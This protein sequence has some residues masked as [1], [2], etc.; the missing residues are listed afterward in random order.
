MRPAHIEPS[1]R[2]PAVFHRAAREALRAMPRH[3]REVF[4]QAIDDAQCGDKPINASPLK[5]YRGAGVLEIAED[6]E[7][8]TYRAVYTV[9][10]AGAV[11]V[12]HAFQKKS[13]R[14][15]ETP[16]EELTLVDQRLRWAEEH[17]QREFRG[18]RG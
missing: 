14:G 13:K 4:G 18:G 3:V 11:Y 15:V 7:T 10:F 16:R 12:L 17:Y 1:E 8:D 6:Y 9:R 2:K 5:G